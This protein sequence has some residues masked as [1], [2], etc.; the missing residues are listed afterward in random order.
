LLSSCT[1]KHFN[2]VFSTFPSSNLWIYILLLYTTQ[3][4]INYQSQ[5]PDSLGHDNPGYTQY[6]NEEQSNHAVVVDTRND[7]DT[8]STNY[9]GGGGGGGGVIDR[10]RLNVRAKTTGS[11]NN[12]RQH[13][14]SFPL[15]I[16]TR[17]ILSPTA[18]QQH[19]S[20]PQTYTNYSLETDHHNNG[21]GGGGNIISSSGAGQQSSPH[22]SQNNLARKQ[23]LAEIK[24][25]D[26]LMRGSVTSDAI[27]FW[28][29]HLDDLNHRLAA[30]TK[31][32]TVW[33][34]DGGG[35]GRSTPN[36]GGGGGGG[37]GNQQQTRGTQ[38]KSRLYFGLP[39]TSIDEPM[40]DNSM[41]GEG[42]LPTIMDYNHSVKVDATTSPSMG[43]SIN[44]QQQQQ[45][46]S[47]LPLCDVVAPSDLPGGYMF[48]A[49][50]GDKK[51]LATVP[52]GGVAKGQRFTSTMRE[53]E[54]IQIP[55]PLGAWRDYPTECFNDGIFHPLF[56]NTLF[57][58][59]S[60]LFLFLC[61]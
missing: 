19:A 41:G 31:A 34:G 28:K 37:Y 32:E 6:S 43:G 23:L 14:Q 39:S 33:T 29:K 44:R 40:I 60:K 26:F 61:L 52:V 27:N 24:E 38:S 16:P 8:T 48:E 51:F 58:P 7:Y 55:V 45:Q 11:M 57:F 18:A 53:L 1:K 15:V 50:L 21:G 13:S 59:C 25:T 5:D 12:N 49:Q 4:L 20:S 22:T 47:P 42:V 17:A 3:Y 36:S 35:K 46:Q 54:N 2:F 10:A 56:C 30:M 9:R